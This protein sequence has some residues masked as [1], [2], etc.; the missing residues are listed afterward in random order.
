MGRSGVELAA[1]PHV[2][3]SKSSRTTRF[4]VWLATGFGVGQWCPAP[5]TAGAAMG[6]ILAWGIS[7]LPRL[8]FQV[9]AI[10]ALNAIG[11]PLCTA[12]G[13]SLGGEKDNQTIIWDEFAS[14]PILFLFTLFSG[15]PVGLAGFG[16]HRLFD[17]TK[18]PP[19]RQLERLPD[20]LGVMADDWAAAIYA[21]ASLAILVHFAGPVLRLAV[22]G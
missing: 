20:G 22:S 16:L 9:L 7:L 10:A 12:A 15:W 19:A 3:D 17:I 21:G 4:V 14:L 6:V 18:P 2:A 5:G 8:E 1:M 13:R 11:V